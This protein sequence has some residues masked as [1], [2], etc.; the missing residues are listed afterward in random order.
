MKG[1]RGTWAD[2]FARTA[3]RRAERALVEEYATTIGRL[4]TRLDVVGLKIAT[5][6]AELPDMVRGYGPVKHKAMEAYAKRRAQLI[7]ARDLSSTASAKV[8]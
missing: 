8:A 1:L 3:E 4:C 2:P 6:L 5:D 7:E